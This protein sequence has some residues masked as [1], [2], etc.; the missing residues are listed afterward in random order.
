MTLFFDNCLQSCERVLN[1]S[2]CFCLHLSDILTILI[3]VTLMSNTEAGKHLIRGAVRGFS[4]AHRVSEGAALGTSIAA[5]SVTVLGSST[6]GSA[7]LSLGLVS[8]PIAPVVICAVAAIFASKAIISF[9]R[10]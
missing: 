10:D 6:L 3:R 2:S 7:A 4:L 1:S 8:A 9:F 5:S